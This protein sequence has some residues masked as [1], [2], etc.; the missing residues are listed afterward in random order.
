[1]SMYDN[2]IILPRGQQRQRVPAQVNGQHPRFTT[3]D[4]RDVH[5][6]MAKAWL[7]FNRVADREVNHIENDTREPSLSTTEPSVSSVI[8][9]A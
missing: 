3:E 9:G 4:L 2:T 8:K 5:R 1:M 6:Q 7:V